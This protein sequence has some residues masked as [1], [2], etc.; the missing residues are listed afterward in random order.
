MKAHRQAHGDV[1]SSLQQ[2]L[3]QRSERADRI[4][5]WGCAGRRLGW[6]GT[7]MMRYA[8]IMMRTMT[9]NVKKLMIAPLETFDDLLRQQR[10]LLARRC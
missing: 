2:K 1:L 3:R 7:R 9:M 5:R 8:L 4:G 10:R 6:T